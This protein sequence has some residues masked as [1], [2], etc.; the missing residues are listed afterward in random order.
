MDPH[1]LKL[2]EVY[3][4]RAMPYWRCRWGGHMSLFRIVRGGACVLM[5]TAVTLISATSAEAGTTSGD[6]EALVAA[7]QYLSSQ[8]FS[9]KGLIAQLDSPYGSQFTVAQ[10]TYGAE[11]T[12]ANWNKEALLAAKEYLRSQAFSMKGLIAQ[13]D[14]PDGGQ[15]TVAQAIYGVEH[16]GANW[17]KEAYLAA[18]EYLRTQ[19]FSLSG[20]IAQ[21][22]SP[23]G[24]QFT[25]AQ[26]TY[27]AKKAY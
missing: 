23:Y 8:A 1:A 9:M 24:S 11:H 3:A 26:A 15:F 21:L 5:I 6:K 4:L 12:G 19:A 2:D 13:L 10:A 7:K 22:D 17:D 20:L 14:S 16:T 25:V 18:K 27:G